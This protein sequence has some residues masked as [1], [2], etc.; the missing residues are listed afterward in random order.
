MKK[1]LLLIILSFIIC[2]VLPSTNS[3]QSRYKK[4]KRK[5]YRFNAGLVLGVNFSQIDGD[6][7][8]GFNKNGIRAGIKSMY[9]LNEKFDITTGINF[10][11][12]GSRFE[13]VKGR[14]L[15]RETD[16]I[17]HLDYIELPIFLT[18]KILDNTGKG[19]YI[20][21]G[22]SFSRLFNSEIT[23]TVFPLREDVVYGDFQDNFN[24]DEFNLM[25]EAHV[26]FNRR[27]G[28]GVQATYQLNKLFVN[29]NYQYMPNLWISSFQDV[30]FLRNYQ[31]GLL[32]TYHLN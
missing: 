17:I 2:L 25:G 28:I 9:Y 14:R 7:F 11:Q 32:L 6:L 29:E 23:E 20:N 4:E 30:E 19:V 1:V 24:K 26:F 21:L 18:Y 12:R 3:A 8:S 16:R 10:V 5:K 13:I 27:V 31:I 15:N 22:G